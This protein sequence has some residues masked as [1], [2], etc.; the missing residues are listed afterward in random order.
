MVPGFAPP[1]KKSC[2]RPCTTVQ[3]MNGMTAA[4]AADDDDD[5]DDDDN[6][7]NFV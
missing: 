5:D 1:C 4:A 6:L 7:N 3:L 2:G